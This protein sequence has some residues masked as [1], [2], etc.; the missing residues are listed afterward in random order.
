MPA[1]QCNPETEQRLGSSIKSSP[2][3]QIKSELGCGL[4]FRKVSLYLLLI[5]AVYL[6]GRS[7]GYF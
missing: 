5:S 3:Y 4:S 1:N 2:I 7:W 6:L